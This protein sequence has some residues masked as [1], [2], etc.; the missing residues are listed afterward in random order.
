MFKKACTNRLN[1]INSNV[2]DKLQCLCAGCCCLYELHSKGA[3][4]LLNLQL[5]RPLLIMLTRG[6]EWRSF[7]TAELMGYETKTLTLK[8]F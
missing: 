7:T 8:G 6:N 5:K 2:S 1:Q 3:N 4:S